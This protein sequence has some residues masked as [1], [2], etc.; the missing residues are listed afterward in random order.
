MFKVFA[1]FAIVLSVS[2]QKTSALM[3][4]H[5]PVLAAQTHH[6]CNRAPIGGP[7]DDDKECP[8]PE[9]MALYPS[10]D[11][12]NPFPYPIPPFPYP[13]PIPPDTPDPPDPPLPYLLLAEE[14][15]DEDRDGDC[16]CKDVFIEPDISPISPVRNQVRD[17]IRNC[18]QVSWRLHQ[19]ATSFSSFVVTEIFL[20]PC[21]E[22]TLSVVTL[23]N[24]GQCA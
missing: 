20:S 10:P 12:P 14:D 21:L 6:D 23:H 2:A 15:C 3:E 18:L 8:A 13:Y 4:S 17:P 7:I 5:E 11:R 9:N 22:P 19:S 16:D 24:C 1:A